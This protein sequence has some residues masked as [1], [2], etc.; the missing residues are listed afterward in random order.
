M[1]DDIV[2]RLRR[3]TDPSQM[4]MCDPP[5]PAPDSLSYE[6]AAEIERLR[7]RVNL[8]AGYLTGALNVIER[9]VGWDTSEARAALR[10]ASDDA[11]T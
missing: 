10:E 1:T 3:R 9:F 11:A 8:L 7:G 4:L 6:A 2:A 5:K